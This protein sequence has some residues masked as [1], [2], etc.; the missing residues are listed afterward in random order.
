MPLTKIRA[1]DFEIAKLRKE[2]A[3]LKAGKTVVEV[4]ADLTKGSKDKTVLSSEAQRR[5]EV[6]KYFLKEEEVE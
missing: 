4:E 1:Q 5:K 6:D 3:D 2:N